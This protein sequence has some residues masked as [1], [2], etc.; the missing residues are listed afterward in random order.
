M[1]WRS[2]NFSADPNRLQIDFLP[3]DELRGL[4]TVPIS[5]QTVL[6][7]FMNNRAAEALQRHQAA[8][9]YAW[10]REALRVD[11]GFQP[12]Y[13]TLGVV[14][15]QA[16]HLAPA[17]AAFEQALALDDR[18]VAAMWNLAQ[19]LQALGR[20]EEAARWTARRQA[21]E[22]VAPFHYQQ[23][24]EVALARGDD[25]EAR[26]WFQREQRLTGDSHELYFRLAQAYFRLGDWAAA[27]HELQQA[28]ASS[29]GA[30]QQARYAGKLAWLQAQ[31]H[32]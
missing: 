28:I 17:A 8:D 7:M 12:A 14:Y 6:A 1:G 25:A 4:R 3:P 24:G 5:E 23:L 15:Q 16:G 29:P 21:L 18:Q 26:D 27:R 22:P 11:P 31:G 2:I 13:N 30:G 10:V 9:A 20:D 32:L 19:V